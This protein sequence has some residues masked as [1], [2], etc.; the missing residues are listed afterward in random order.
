V[1]R[2]E[3]DPRQGDMRDLTLDEPAALIYCPYRA[4]LYLQGWADR[5]RT[6][7]A[8]SGVR[9][10]VWCR[11]R[12]ILKT[13]SLRRAFRR[14]RRGSAPSDD[15]SAVRRSYWRCRSVQGPGAVARVVEPDR[16]K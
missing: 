11:L 7:P 16:R 1:C 13:V 3:L 9:P 5:R 4:L 12:P 14:S 6:F 2:A 8:T 10:G 15:S